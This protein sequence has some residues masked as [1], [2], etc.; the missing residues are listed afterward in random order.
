MSFFIVKG[1]EKMKKF[2]FAKYSKYSKIL[3]VDCEN[4]GFSLEVIP[5]IL[6]CP[7]EY[8]NCRYQSI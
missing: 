7:K 1:D 2:K 8:G 5:V 4:V 3:L 6:L